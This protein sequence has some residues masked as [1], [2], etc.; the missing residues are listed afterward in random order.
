MNIHQYRKTNW[1]TVSQP[2]AE[3]SADF[4]DDAQQRIS[5]ANL[6]LQQLTGVGITAFASLAQMAG[7]TD[8]VVPSAQNISNVAQAALD[9]ALGAGSSTAA[10]MT[11]ASEPALVPMNPQNVD[12]VASVEENG[13]K[14]AVVEQDPGKVSGEPSP[15]LLVR[16]MYDKDAETDPNWH[17]DIREE[18]LDESAKFGKI[19]KIKVE[20]LKPG[21][22]VYVQFAT[23]EMASSCANAL[24]GRWFDGRQLCVEFVSEDGFPSDVMEVGG[25]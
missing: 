24:A 3:M 20:H 15:Y 11:A 13:A 5:N 21:G 2:G 25:D 12:A 6:A 23:A 16:N 18:F 1:A 7:G 8:L 14:D 22:M 10:T 17:E 4:P 9:A 19:C